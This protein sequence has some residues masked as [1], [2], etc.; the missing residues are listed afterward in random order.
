MPKNTQIETIPRKRDR[1]SVRRC[2]MK[3]IMKIVYR[4]AQELRLAM[5][6]TLYAAVATLAF[7]VPMTAHA[8]TAIGTGVGISRATSTANAGV[9][10]SINVPGGN[11]GA[12]AGSNDSGNTNLSYPHQAPAVFAPSVGSGS[13]CDSYLSLGASGPMFGG[14]FA[15]PMQN[16]NCDMRANTLVLQQLG[17][18]AAAKQR[19]CYDADTAD[20]LAATGFVCTV[21]PRAPK[22]EQTSVAPATVSVVPPATVTPAATA[23]VGEG[24][25]WYLRGVRYI[26]VPC[27]QKHVTHDKEGTCLNKA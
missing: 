21:G 14:S 3:I 10:N 20:A 7:T 12:L 5:K 9:I 22:P 18:R 19:M 1:R 24:S 26:E 27:T 15:F 4:T 13:P 25:V 23:N 6:N 11:R 17:M 16:H 8:Q 2:L